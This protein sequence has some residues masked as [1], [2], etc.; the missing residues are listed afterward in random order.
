MLPYDAM[1]GAVSCAE[2]SCRQKS[3]SRLD[4]HALCRNASRTTPLRLA[5][6]RQQLDDLGEVA[7]EVVVLG[8]EDARDAEL[9]EL[10]RVVV[11]DR[12]ADDHGNLCR[13]DAA[14]AHFVQ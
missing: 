7:R 5:I 2:D 8:R 6:H 11:R 4:A 9:F 13:I 1:P 12:A 3:M 10:P 14:L